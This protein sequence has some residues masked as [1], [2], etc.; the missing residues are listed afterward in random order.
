MGGCGLSAQLV[1]EVDLRVLKPLLGIGF[2]L[3]KERLH[4]RRRAQGARF[5]REFLSNFVPAGG[6]ENYFL[7]HFPRRKTPDSGSVVMRGISPIPGLNHRRGF[8]LAFR[9]SCGGVDAAIRAFCSSGHDVTAKNSCRAPIHPQP[10]ISWLRP[11]PSTELQNTSSVSRS[12]V[13]FSS[14]VSSLP[15]RNILRASHLRNAQ[16]LHTISCPVSCCFL[17]VWRRVRSLKL[18]RRSQLPGFPQYTERA[19]APFSAPFSVLSNC[20]I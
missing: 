6:M 7:E 17:C 15:L 8:T 12:G 13:C 16:G 1:D 11:P 3:L 20:Y 10:A 18:P 2:A 14:F 5:H 19:K 9:N 4:T